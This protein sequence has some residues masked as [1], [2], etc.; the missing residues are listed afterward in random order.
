MS[1]FRHNQLETIAVVQCF[2]RLFGR[3]PSGLK[4]RRNG[5]N[6]GLPER[7]RSEAQRSFCKG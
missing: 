3:N 7:A 1:F 6:V 5:I 2:D 4:S